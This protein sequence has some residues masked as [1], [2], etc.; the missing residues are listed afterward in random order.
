MCPYHCAVGELLCSGL[1]GLE[2]QSSEDRAAMMTIELAFLLLVFFGVTIFGQQLIYWSMYNARRAEEALSAAVEARHGL[3]EKL[4]D[5]EI[6]LSG[7]LGLLEASPSF[8]AI[9]GVDL[10]EWK[11]TFLDFLVA[12]DVQRVKEF[13]Q[14]A[15]KQG[16]SSCIHATLKRRDGCGIEARFYHAEQSGRSDACKHRLALLV[17]SNTES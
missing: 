12:G 16:A 14:N 10:A 4:C 8:R 3:I 6:E 2:V 1:V 17:L 9:V 7:E 13:L 11:G 15:G 5:A